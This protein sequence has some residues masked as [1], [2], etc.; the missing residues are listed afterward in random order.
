MSALLLWPLLGLVGL[1]I[2][3]WIAVRDLHA[4]LG[5]SR[6][7]QQQAACV[8]VGLVALGLLIVLQGFNLLAV[9]EELQIMPVLAHWIL[10]TT[11]LLVVGRWPRTL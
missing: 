1:M 10:G 7:L 3:W 4:W 11:V 2:S 8:L 9:S 5:K 6:Q